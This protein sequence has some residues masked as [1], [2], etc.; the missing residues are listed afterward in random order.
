MEEDGRH[1]RGGQRGCVEVPSNDLAHD[2]ATEGTERAQEG[3]SG[4]RM[5]RVFGRRPICALYRSVPQQNMILK[6]ASG[7]EERCYMYTR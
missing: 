1:Q 7:G 6:H 2:F 5:E 4:P 3:R